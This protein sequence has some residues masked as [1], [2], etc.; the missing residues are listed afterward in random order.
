VTKTL[1]LV[2]IVIGLVIGVWGSL[3]FTTREKVLDIGP[4][5]A[6]KTTTRRIPYAPVF[7]GLVLVGGVVLLVTPRKN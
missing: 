4:L 1:G 7:G 2:L 6:T 5:E 3:G